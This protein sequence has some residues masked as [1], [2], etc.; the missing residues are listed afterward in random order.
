MLSLHAEYILLIMNEFLNTLI[1][2]GTMPVLAALLL[3][4]MTTIS[5]CPFCSNL[6][7]VSY[8]VREV[9]SKRRVWINSLLYMLGKIVAY[10][11]LSAVFIAGAQIEP[12]QKWFERWGEPLL[13]PFLIVCGLFMFVGGWREQHHSHEHSGT[14]KVERWLENG[15]AKMQQWLQA[16]SALYSFVMGV[17]FSLAFCPYSGVLFFGM[18]LPLTMSAPLSWGWS[19]PVLYGIGTGLPVL[20]VAVLLAWSVESIGSINRQ[21]QRVEIWIR[22]ISALLFVAVGVWL[23]VENL[24]G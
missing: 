5:P 10:C 2:N 9:G 12:V 17:V 4:L 11:A 24:I 1:L 21:I 20:V 18:L 16:R 8:L 22:S 7:A 15:S 6:T 19:M 23:V 13:G 3:G 14:T